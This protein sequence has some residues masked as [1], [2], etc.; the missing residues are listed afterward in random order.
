MHARSSRKQA[1]SPKKRET[2]KKMNDNWGPREERME[3]D[4]EKFAEKARKNGDNRTQD[5]RIN[6]SHRRVA[7][8]VYM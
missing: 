7:Q 3:E 4:E 8:T 6:I 1:N 5:N 2:M